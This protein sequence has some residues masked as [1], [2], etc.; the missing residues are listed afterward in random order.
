MAE[1]SPHRVSR[2]SIAAGSF[3]AISSLLVGRAASSRQTVKG[4]CEREDAVALL[5]DWRAGKSVYPSLVVAGPQ[6][7]WVPFNHP[8]FL[9][10]FLIPSGWTGSAA[11]TDTF[12]SDGEPLWQDSPPAVPQLIL[13]RVSS[14]DGDSVFDYVTGAIPNALLT[15]EET[16]H[17]ASQGLLGANPRLRQVC[18][19][20]DGANPL[21]PAWFRADRHRSNLLVSFGNALQLPDTYLPA[22]VVG[23]TLLYTPRRDAEQV[24]YD[25]FLR[26]LHQFLGGGSGDPTPTPTPT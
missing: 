9:G 17:L 14:A 12:S 20:D 5:L 10:P 4:D 16:A 15:V 23:Y 7:D 6:P 18:L 26:I 11:W 21:S 13:S 8:A 2:R 1:S 25:V 24:M 22:T 19:V 3:V